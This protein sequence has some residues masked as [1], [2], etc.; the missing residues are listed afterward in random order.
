MAT[1]IVH[2]DGDQLYVAVTSPATPS[3]GDPVMVGDLPGVAL[4]DEDSDGKCTVKFNGVAELS[5]KGEG[6][7]GN[8]AVAAGDILYYEAGQTPPINKDST[9][10]KRFGYALEAVASGATA[11]IRVKIGY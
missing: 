11:T 6:A 7:S 4:T 10:G 1:N 9:N 3:A 8:T 5:V 2:E